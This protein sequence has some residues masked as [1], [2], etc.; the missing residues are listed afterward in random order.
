MDDNRLSL[1]LLRKS[2]FIRTQYMRKWYKQGTIFR[3]KKTPL[4]QLKQESL[5]KGLTCLDVILNSE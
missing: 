5:Y 3:H 1:L 2:F 4:F